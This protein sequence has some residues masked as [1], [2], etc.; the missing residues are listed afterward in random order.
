MIYI[1]I[2][3]HI[4]TRL[5]VFVCM[6]TIYMDMYNKALTSSHRALYAF[7]K[8]LKCPIFSLFIYNS[9]FDGEQDFENFFLHSSDV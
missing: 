3:I 7:L 2:C 8:T 4:Y 1:Y 9:I 6:F 5:F